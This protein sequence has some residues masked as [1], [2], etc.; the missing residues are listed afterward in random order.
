[1][2][3]TISL[4]IGLF[5]LAV[6]TTLSQAPNATAGKIHGHVVNATGGPQANGTVGLSTDSGATLMFSFP[7]TRTGDYAGSAAPGTYRLVYRAPYTAPGKFDDYYENIK[8][9]AGEDLV[10]DVDMSRQEFADRLPSDVRK[11][12]EAIKKH[13]ADA[14]KANDAIKKDNADLIAARSASPASPKMTNEEVIQLVTAGLSDQVVATSI[15]QASNRDFDLT[16]TGLITLKKAGVSDAVIVVMQEKGS[17]SQASTAGGA[18]AS[19]APPRP[20]PTSDNG[21]SDIDFMGVFQIS[22]SPTGRVWI[23]VATI[24]SRATYAKEVDIEYVKNGESTKG[25]FNVGAGQKID[26]QLDLN[27]NP[28]SN[29]HM[30]ACR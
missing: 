21:C 22:A 6:S 4:W 17:T 18:Q 25:T 27:N 11:S 29:V 7:V 2:K 1:M 10:Q 30:T 16:P 23:Y 8:I 12:L 26:A 9:L 13:N 5:A 14:M 24:R 15:R 28:P 20:A 3:R 19:E